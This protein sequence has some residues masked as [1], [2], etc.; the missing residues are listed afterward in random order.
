[1]KAPLFFLICFQLMTSTESKIRFLIFPVPLMLITDKTLLYTVIISF[2]HVALVLKTKRV[3]YKSLL[4]ALCQLRSD[5]GAEM[6]HFSWEGQS[7]EVCVH[8]VIRNIALFI[9]RHRAHVRL[10]TLFGT[11]WASKCLYYPSK[12]TASTRDSS[13]GTTEQLNR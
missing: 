6:I 4:L 13:S 9:V 11:A 2:T 1:M 5:L 7:K 12:S 10:H 8:Y 3:S